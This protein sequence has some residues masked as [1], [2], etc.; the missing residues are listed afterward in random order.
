VIVFVVAGSRARR[1]RQ[2]LVDFM[3]GM[4]RPNTARAAL[5][6][7]ATTTRG[8][9]SRRSLSSH[10]RQAMSPVKRASGSSPA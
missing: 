6:P 10:Q 1:G 7:S 9:T 3:I 5:P 4:A 2:L 8:R